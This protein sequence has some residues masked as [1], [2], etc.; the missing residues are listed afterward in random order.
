ML[1]LLPFQSAVALQEEA[2]VSRT[3]QVCLLH[4]PNQIGHSPVIY[5]EYL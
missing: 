2:P 4:L 1:K 5:I 3:A